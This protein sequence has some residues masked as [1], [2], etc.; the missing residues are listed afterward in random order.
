MWASKRRQRG[1]AMVETAIT[2]S[3]F[4]MLVFAIIE[5]SMAYFTWARSSEAARDMLRHA[6]V[7]DPAAN[8]SGL[9]CPGGAP[10]V[11][12]CNSTACADLLAVGRR[13]APFLEPGNVRITY[14]CSTAGN[15][16]RPVE[17]PVTTVTLEV[18]GVIHRYIVPGLLGLATEQ[19]L[20]AARVT[21]TGEDLY[22]EV[23]G[24]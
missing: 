3:L 5:F 2:L 17:W 12:A 13:V 19:R 4:L 20:P 1:A 9:A 7:N 22:T 10:V 23:G 15:P 6:I 11:L 14:A 16:D 18:H 21:R 24:S 8:L